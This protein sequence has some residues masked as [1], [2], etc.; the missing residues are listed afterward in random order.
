[1]F[2]FHFES[3]VFLIIIVISS[4]VIGMIVTFLETHS[5]NYTRG[6]KGTWS[7]SPAMLTVVPVRNFSMSAAVGIGASIKMLVKQSWIDCLISL[8]NLRRLSVGFSSAPGCLSAICFTT[9]SLVWWPWRFRIFESRKYHLRSHRHGTWRVSRWCGHRHAPLDESR[10]TCHISSSRKLH[11]PSSCNT[12]L[13]QEAC[14]S[15]RYLVSS[16]LFGIWEIRHK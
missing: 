7:V 9:T 13:L 6:A 5:M 14:L 8:A 15:V 11:C 10:Q 12:E 3:T 2:F 16:L 4:I 1:M